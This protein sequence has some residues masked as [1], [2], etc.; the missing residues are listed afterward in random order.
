MDFLLEEE[1]IDILTFCLNNQN[2]DDVDSKNH[3]MY[4]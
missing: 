4:G 1:L 2:S 3:P